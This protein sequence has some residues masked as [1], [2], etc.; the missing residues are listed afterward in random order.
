[1]NLKIPII[2]FACICLLPCGV[3]G[4]DIE[5]TLDTTVRCY[6]EPLDNLRIAPDEFGILSLSCVGTADSSKSDVVFSL[7]GD[8]IENNY[9]FPLQSWSSISA[10]SIDAIGSKCV[11]LRMARPVHETAR[12][13]TSAYR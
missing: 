5:D 4:R 9:S 6:F 7:R 10:R 2:V 3:Y 13:H 8:L 1:M 12:S 11:T